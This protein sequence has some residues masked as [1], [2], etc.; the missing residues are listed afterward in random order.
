[1]GPGSGRKKRQKN[2]VLDLWVRWGERALQE[3]Y[4]RY[5]G[6]EDLNYGRRKENLAKKGRGGGGNMALQSITGSGGEKKKGPTPSGCKAFWT[7]QDPGLPRL[8]GRG[9]EWK[10]GN[11]T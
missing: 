7:S 10:R 11:Y 8:R 5:Q 2:P 1:V 3:K 9:S 6:G 4:F